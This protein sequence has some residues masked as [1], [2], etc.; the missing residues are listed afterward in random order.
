MRV[1]GN[2]SLH[3]TLFRM[4]DSR[5]ALSSHDTGLSL[6][7]SRHVADAEAERQRST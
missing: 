6:P 5:K 3:R 2:E 1:P 7:L 4:V